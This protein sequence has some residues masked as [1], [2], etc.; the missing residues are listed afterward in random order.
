MSIVLAGK[1]EILGAMRPGHSMI[2]G[3][4]RPPS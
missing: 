2:V 1:P 3:T 4:R